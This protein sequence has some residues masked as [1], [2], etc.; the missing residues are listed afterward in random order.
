[1][2]FHD[3]RITTPRAERCDRCRYCRK[4]SPANSDYEQQSLVSGEWSRLCKR[5]ARTRLNSTGLLIGFRKI[6]TAPRAAAPP[7]DAP[8]LRDE[9]IRSRVNV[10]RNLRVAAGLE[11][12]EL[13]GTAKIHGA[14]A[15]DP[16]FPKLAACTQAEHLYVRWANETILA[17]LDER[18]R[19]VEA[20][21]K[22]EATVKRM[23]RAGGQ[24]SNI[25]YNLAQS[26]RWPHDV[27]ATLDQCRREWDAARTPP[28]SFAP[29]CANC[30]D[31]LYQ[32]RLA[33][34]GDGREQMR[35]MKGSGAGSEY[36]ALMPN[37][38]MALMASIS[39]KLASFLDDER[40]RTRAL[41]ALPAE[42]PP[43]CAWCGKAPRE[44]PD[45]CQQTE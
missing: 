18:D 30:G 27:R 12:I 2:K 9:D 39:D 38:I 28:E 20:L 29:H 31:A 16:R 1:M 43:T 40:D 21:A 24:L 15:V 32:H 45:E 17:L 8:T 25:A 22:A 4:R 44:N 13:T 5:C 19:A 41:A 3:E 34:A 26:D 14:I 35:C 6:E 23:S 33:T 7:A 37:S 36:S 10:S 11:A 42:A